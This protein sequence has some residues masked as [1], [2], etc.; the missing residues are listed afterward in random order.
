MR[1]IALSKIQIFQLIAVF[2]LVIFV[3]FSYRSETTI[4]WL[5]YVI[6]LLNIGLWILRLLERRRKEKQ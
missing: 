5:F 1:F 2:I 3:I 4:T 6:A